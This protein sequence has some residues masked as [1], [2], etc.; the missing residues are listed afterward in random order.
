VDGYLTVSVLAM[1]AVW[2]IGVPIALV[3]ALVPGRAT[4]PWLGRTGL[5]VTAIVSLPGMVLASSLE[6]QA[7]QHLASAPQRV[8][9]VVAVVML[10][11][12]GLTVS[13]RPHPGSHRR[14]PRPWLVGAVALVASSLYFLAPGYV[15]AWVGVGVDLAL[16]AAFT[17]LVARWSRGAGWGAVHRFALAAGATLTYAWLGFTQ[18]P[19][20]GVAG[21][22]HRLGNVV[23]AL[24]AVA[25]LAIAGRTVRSTPPGRGRA[26][27]THASAGDRIDQ[28]SRSAGPR[29]APSMTA[30]DITILATVRPLSSPEV[31]RLGLVPRTEVLRNG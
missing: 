24:A 10:A 22:V 28:E 31:K 5:T 27:G 14:P 29:A 3:E 7:G 18:P 16:A 6:H 26:G 2:S 20:D 21:T 25:L 13:R 17:A 23:F 8:G 15:P 30:M 12:A 11:A 9:T 1:H 19:F 4:A